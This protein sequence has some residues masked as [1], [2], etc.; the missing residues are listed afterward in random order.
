MQLKRLA[1]R[2]VKWSRFTQNM[3]K[4][5]KEQKIPLVIE[6]ISSVGIVEKSGERQTKAWSTASLEYRKM[7]IVSYVSASSKPE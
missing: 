3:M 5:S 4:L 6:G 7:V 2:G 1:R